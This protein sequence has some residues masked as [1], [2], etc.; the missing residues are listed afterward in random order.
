MFGDR[1]VSY[2]SVI[3]IRVNQII[4]RAMKTAPAFT[5][6]ALMTI[7]ARMTRQKLCARKVGKTFPCLKGRDLKNP[8][9]ETL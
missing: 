5:K 8:R 4:I 9:F 1:A 7:H 6:A 2:P 3:G